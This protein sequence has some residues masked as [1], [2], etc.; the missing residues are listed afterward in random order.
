MIRS[1]SCHLVVE[2]VPDRGDDVLLGHAVV[3][4]LLEHVAERGVGIG[5]RRVPRG[6]DRV[7]D[8]LLTSA[9]SASLRRRR[10]GVVLVAAR[11]RTGSAGRGAF[12]CSTSSR[13][14]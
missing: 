4:R 11:R 7:V 14:R 13:E 5:V 9:R 8:L 3:L 12:A 2:R 1:S 6:A 10:P